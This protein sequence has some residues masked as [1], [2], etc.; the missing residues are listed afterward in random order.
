MKTADQVFAKEFKDMMNGRR[1]IT[2][3]FNI[4]DIPVPSI[5]SLLTN[6]GKGEVCLVKGIKE[7]FFD[8]LNNSEVQ[9]VT[10]P[11]LMKR[12]VLSDGSFRV[13]RNGDYVLIQ[14]PVKQGFVPIHSNKSIGL[15]NRIVVNGVERKHTLSEGYKYV[16]F[17]ELN[18]EKRYIYIVP[19]ENVYPMNLCALVITPNTHRNFYKGCKLALQ[20]GHYLYLYVIP[21]KAGRET[22]GYRVLGVKPSPNFDIE[23]KKLLEYW[24]RIGVIFDLNLTAL[25]NQV[26]GE[27]NVGIMDLI[28]TLG[29]EDYIRVNNYLGYEPP[30]LTES[31]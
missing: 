4:T 27:N 3:Y 6:L 2:G 7:P 23:V 26:G 14:V 20:N 24:M 13:D 31:Q 11:T 5:P 8:K 12:Q 16:D 9:L 22:R 29:P 17:F 1:S 21:Y 18:G 19:K 28:G 15:K 30:I 10:T 25:E